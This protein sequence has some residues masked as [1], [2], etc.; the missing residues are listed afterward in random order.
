MV[1]R[2]YGA[3]RNMLTKVQ[4]FYISSKACVRVGS[5]HLGAPLDCFLMDST[6]LFYCYQY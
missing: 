3:A 2:L 5:R 6:A 1:L 4:S